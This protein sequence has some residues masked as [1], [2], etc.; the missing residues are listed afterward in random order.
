MSEV[1][2]NVLVVSAEGLMTTFAAAVVTEMFWSSGA[3]VETGGTGSA[4]DSL[5][6]VAVE[7]VSVEGAK[8]VL[9]PVTFASPAI[10]GDKAGSSLTE[11]DSCNCGWGV[12]GW[13]DR[14]ADTV[15]SASTSDGFSDKGSNL[16]SSAPLLGAA[17]ETVVGAELKRLPNDMDAEGGRVAGAKMDVVILFACGMPNEKGGLLPPVDPPRL[18][19]P[20]HPVLVNWTLP[21]MLPVVFVLVDV[22]DVLV[23]MTN[24]EVASTG[25]SACRGLEKVNPEGIVEVLVGCPPAMLLDG[26]LMLILVLSSA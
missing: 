20:E 13:E 21:N 23:A 1:V 4:L 5:T 26:A 7:T 17:E 15:V 6:Q 25:F 9:G 18:S 16:T 14:G 10:G 11:L 3:E 22:D 19:T 24:V 12:G 8:E 2:A